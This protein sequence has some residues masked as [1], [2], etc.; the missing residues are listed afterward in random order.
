V[1][2]KQTIQQRE[3]ETYKY[4]LEYKRI[5][6]ILDKFFKDSIKDL[7]NYNEIKEKAIKKI[8]GK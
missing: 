1:A 7:P 3:Q 4:V 6:K 5:S 8:L 2:T